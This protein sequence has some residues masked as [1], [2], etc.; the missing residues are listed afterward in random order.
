MRPL[1][2]VLTAACTS[3]E[4]VDTDR[5]TGSDPDTSDLDTT[6][7]D[8]DDVD[9][10]DVDTDDPDCTDDAAEPDDTVDAATT[11]VLP[12]AITGVICR[13]DPDYVLVSTRRRCEVTADLT[14]PEE[15]GDLDLILYRDGVGIGSSVNG[16]SSESIGWTADADGDWVIGVE[17]RTNAT[18]TYTLTIDEQCGAVCQDDAR[19]PDDTQATASV[20]IDQVEVTGRACEADPDWFQV[21]AGTG[22]LV[23]YTATPVITGTLSMTLHGPNGEVGPASDRGG[24]L[25]LR[26]IVSGTHWL[27]VESTVDVNYGLNG[28]ANQCSSQPVQCP[29]NDQFEPNDTRPAAPLMA[30]GTRI[31]A[32]SCGNDD[33]YRLPAAPSCTGTVD[34]TFFH[35]QG[36]LDMDLINTSGQVIAPANSETNNERIEMPLPAGDV[37]VRVYGFGEADNSYT[38]Q[39]TL[40]CP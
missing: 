23:D 14:F 36:D 2:L 11:A 31:G 26:T 24:Q 20:L 5:G 38:L 28:S 7:V 16:T 25:V 8:T 29:G 19:E 21:N 17:G 32:S 22:C 15:G 27:E 18:N 1:L 4:P 39:T 10:D 13:N 40:T 12:A 9:T 33:W 3:L 34:L 35:N 30:W 6:D 37:Y